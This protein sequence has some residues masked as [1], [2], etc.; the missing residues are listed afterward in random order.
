MA[1]FV[2]S[3]IIIIVFALTVHLLFRPRITFMESLVQCGVA[4]VI[5]GIVLLAIFHKDLDDTAILNG[6]VTDKQR[7]RVSCS[8]SYSC[9]CY[10]TCSGTGS[11]RTCT[12]HCSTCYEHSYD[13]DWRVSTTV[14]NLEID[15]I[16]RQGTHEPPR[17][18]QVQI[19]E[20]AA[21]TE[22]Y[23]NYIKASPGSLF[24]MNQ[25]ADDATKFP[26]MFPQYP[27][28]YDYYR[29]N[30][31]L[32]AGG[33]TYPQSKE[34]NDT[35]NNALR[36]LGPSKQVNI[37]VL[38]AKTTNP[39]YRYA[40]ER[41]WIGGKKNDVLVVIGMDNSNQFSWVDTITFG[42][43]SG[44]E[45]LAVLMRDRVKAVAK[46]QQLGN[47]QVLAGAIISTVSTDFHRKSMKDFEYLKGDYSPSTKALMWFAIIQ[48]LVL[49][50]TTFFFYHYELERGDWASSNRY[51]RF[52]PKYE[53]HSRAYRT[54]R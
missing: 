33:A 13:V 18:T 38:F 10:T 32:T 53:I 20:P 2:T 42:K 37:V 5:A 21:R 47:A 36:T 23:R 25:T 24:A 39:E 44:N 29:V 40:L 9:N 6:Q 34:L 52:I 31:I 15:R 50:G 49:T 12:Q 17:W 26:N 35:L 7:V 11:S 41:A 8:H 27:R 28:V 19:G 3:L 22:S 54:R 1:I 46:D 51:N 43:N 14:G 16:N 30:R 48:L 4:S 45:M